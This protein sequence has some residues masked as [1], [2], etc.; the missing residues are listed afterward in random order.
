MA[1]LRY[2]GHS[3]FEIRGKDT[4]ILIDP[5]LSGNPSGAA[6]Q[7]SEFTDVRYIFVTHGHGDH[8]GDTVSIASRTGA[9]V[10]TNYE[11]C[12]YLG[13]KG[14]ACHAMHIGGTFSFPFGRV[15]MTPA[16]HGSD[17]MEGDRMIPGGNPC[18][19]LFDVDGERIYH[20][21]DTGLT[22]DMQLL[23]AEKVKAALLPI[24]GNFVMD[25]YDAARAVEFVRPEIAVPM[26]YDTFPVIAA[27]PHEFERL[28]GATATVRI[29]KTGDTL[30]L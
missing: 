6:A 24:G 8:L 29:M 4:V 5:F 21:G 30:A 19:F 20:A 26:H 23:A 27:D 7:E 9:T 18:G 1:T 13:K 28:V 14:V 11:I 3:A 17:I 12:H 15:K 2:L 16:L 22:M 25:V 10:V